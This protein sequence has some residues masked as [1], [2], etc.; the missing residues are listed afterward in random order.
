M[1]IYDRVDQI[2]ESRRMSRR[3]LALLAGI[4]ENTISAAFRRKSKRV[5]LENIVRISRA[6]DLSPKEL[7]AGT[8]LETWMDA[9][10]G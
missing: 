2:L 4:S 9:I 1:T 6:L 3:Q 8:D 5:S 10:F 7:C